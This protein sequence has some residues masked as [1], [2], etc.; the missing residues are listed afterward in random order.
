LS[1]RGEILAQNTLLQLSAMSASSGRLVR[2]TVFLAGK[3]EE[4][5]YD[6]FAHD[7]QGMYG[8][9]ARTQPST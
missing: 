3:V 8:T 5:T 2:G 6:Y 9:P 7:R 4:N 1:G